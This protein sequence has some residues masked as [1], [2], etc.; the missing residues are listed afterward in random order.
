MS[1][2]IGVFRALKLFVWQMSFLLQIL[3]WKPDYYNKISDLPQ[4]MPKSLQDHIK[5]LAKDGS[6]MVS[7]HFILHIHQVHTRF[8]KPI[9]YQ[10]CHKKNTEIHNIHAISKHMSWWQRIHTYNMRKVY[11]QLKI[12]TVI[13][14]CMEQ[15]TVN[16]V[17]LYSQF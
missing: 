11:N 13:S 6:A 1:Y 17:I 10:I 7:S 16:P 14:Q 8:S 3:K 12:N 9:G 5:E 2:C 4:S 15:W